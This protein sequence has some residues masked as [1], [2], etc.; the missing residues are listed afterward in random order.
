ML[1]PTLPVEPP[2]VGPGVLL[3]SGGVAPQDGV[4]EAPAL[5]LLVSPVLSVA[6]LTQVLFV[7]PRVLGLPA[8]S[9]GLLVAGVVVALDVFA[10]AASPGEPVADPTF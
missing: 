9:P 7:P 4:V 6:L 3:T 10:G 1:P 8:A 2:T 5:I